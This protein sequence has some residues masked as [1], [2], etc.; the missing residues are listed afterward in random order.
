VS[1]L[2][3]SGEFPIQLTSI[4]TCLLVGG[5]MGRKPRVIEIGAKLGGT[6]RLTAAAEPLTIRGL[7]ERLAPI[8][9]DT[10]ATVQQL[11]H[12][13]REGLLRP[14]QDLHSGPGVHRLY[15]E[16]AVYEAT[17]LSV[18]ANAGLPISG[19]QVLAE[20]MAQARV[21]IARRKG[22]KGRKRPHLILVRSA[23][24]MTAAAVV[25]AG[26]KLTDSRGFKAAEAVVTI[27]IDLGKLFAQLD[28]AG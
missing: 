20:A 17:I 7:A 16:A 21:E 3:K 4:F 1:I 28:R 10:D 8:A 25:E 22:G 27:D 6:G 13:T 18:V 12:W 24:G 11:R 23:L 9:P 14:V 5:F 19:S 15:D 26:E 2:K